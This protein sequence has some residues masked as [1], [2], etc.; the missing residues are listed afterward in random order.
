M[1]CTVVVGKVSSLYI[2][3][4]LILKTR[5]DHEAK[6]KKKRE[7]EIGGKSHLQ[8][9]ENMKQFIVHFSLFDY[10]FPKDAFRNRNKVGLKAA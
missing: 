6:S 7:R 5:K 9:T 10:L 2:Y 8:A 4:V 3:L 1:Q